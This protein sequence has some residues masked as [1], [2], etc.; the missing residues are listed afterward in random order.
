MS[1]LEGTQL[2]PYTIIRLLG[3]GG[4]ARVYLAR[5]NERDQEVAIKVVHE[6]NTDFIERFRREIGAIDSLSHEHILPA[7]DYDTQDHWHYLVM[8]HIKGGTL[9]HLIKKSALS[10]AHAGEILYQLA[11]AL[12][13]AHD[14][15]IIHRDIKPS[16]ILMRDPHYAYLADFGLAKSLEATQEMTLTQ[17]GTL[18]GTPEY[19]AP[20]LA[21]GPATT[22]SDIYALGVVLY[23]MLTGRLPF[24]A[25]TPIAVYW[26]QIRERPRPPSHWKPNLSPAID[27]VV[28]RALAKHPTHRYQ[29]VG[30]MADDFQIALISPEILTM[31][32]EEELYEGTSFEP[33]EEPGEEETSY[34]EEPEAPSH[35]SRPTPKH[36]SRERLV[37]PT[38]TLSPPTA[39]PR[40]GKITPY[41]GSQP[42]YTEH[43]SGARSIPPSR[44]ALA[45]R[46]RSQLR[47]RQIRILSI[48]LIGLL[49][50]VGLPMAFIY[51]IFV[52]HSNAQHTNDMPTI[53]A[54]ARNTSNSNIAATATAGPVATLTSQEPMLTNPLTSNQ[55]GILNEVA[56]HCSFQ[57][58]GYHVLVKQSD[59]LQPCPLRNQ[60]LNDG[61]LQ[62]DVT[63]LNGNNAGMLLRLNG[64]QFYDFEINDQGQFFFRRHDVG[65]GVNYVDLIRPTIS[66][67]IKLGQRNTLLAIAR[68]ADFKLYI[69]GIFVGETS[70]S[71][72]SSGQIAL[73]AGT[74]A[75]Q[76][77]GD[78]L[79]ND[80]K[81]YKL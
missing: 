40:S 4:M 61:A 68:N 60:V 78:G 79:F 26:K 10:P 66:T 27:Y 3:K 18:L 7:Y 81:L 50:I 39:S 38:N 75:P 37:L 62:V 28:M 65:S 30:E 80:L 24:T 72:Y 45:A 74:L 44:A 46:K 29:S 59:Y 73:T 13:T 31:D 51:Y 70:D 52:T 22:S 58:D 23:Q 15:G 6:D 1:E 54:T 55:D 42:V 11:D 9:R 14:Q 64:E 41:H 67:A 35:P 32:N 8:P 43:S 19:M 20:D 36:T 17:S 69:N 77:N 63:L 12:Q 21:E 76:Q 48:I 49:L 34:R 2:G 56:N 71:F 5:D 25:E 16:N 57:N 53:T 47:K 33:E